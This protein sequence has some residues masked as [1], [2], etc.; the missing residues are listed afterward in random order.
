MLELAGASV[1]RIRMPQRLWSCEL[2]R[3]L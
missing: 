3:L 2:A 1:A